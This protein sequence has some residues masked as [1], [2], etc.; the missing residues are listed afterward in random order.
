MP[1]HICGSDQSSYTCQ[2]CKKET[3]YSHAR[4]VDKS[5]FCINC[6]K[7]AK[8]AKKEKSFL[9]AAFVYS[10]VLT[11]GIGAIFFVGE[12]AI[13]GLLET[14]SSLLPDTAKSLVALFRGTS[15]ALLLGSVAIT[16]LLFLASKLTKKKPRQQPVQPKQ[17]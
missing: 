14:Y 3:C 15:V 6:L 8:P 1:C 4:T 5:V 2:S 16:V 12:Y 7:N 13:F 11:V 17:G 10:L 9:E